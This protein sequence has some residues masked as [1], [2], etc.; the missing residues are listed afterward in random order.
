MMDTVVKLSFMEDGDEVMYSRPYTMGSRPVILK[1]WA[2]NFDFNK[3]MLQT[4]PF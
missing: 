3:E 2:K 1:V 4:I